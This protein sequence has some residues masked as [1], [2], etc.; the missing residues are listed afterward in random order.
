MHT[1]SG[2]F[3]GY[4]SAEKCLELLFPH[5]DGLCLRSFRSLQAMQRIPH[6][7]VGRRTLFNPHEVRAALERTCKRGVAR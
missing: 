4:C 6:L 2:S 1:L 5:G 3:E 7:K